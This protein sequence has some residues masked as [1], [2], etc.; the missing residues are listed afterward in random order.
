MWTTIL[1]LTTPGAL[2]I[3]PVEAR[4]DN[5]VPVEGRPLCACCADDGEWY[6]TA[7]RISDSQFDALANLRFS[8]VANRY[9]SPADESDLAAAYSLSLRRAGRRWE[10]RLRD[11][12]GKSGTLSFT[13]PTSAVSFGSDMGEAEPGSAGPILYKEWR[14][15]GTARVTGIFKRGMTGAQRFRL[16]LQGRGNHCTDVGDYKHWKLQIYGGRVSHAFYGTLE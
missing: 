8:A 15:S 16:I 13:I 10:L 9:Q 7:Q 12:Q 11:E 4:D 1:I 3:R 14:V 2:L 6:E 5:N